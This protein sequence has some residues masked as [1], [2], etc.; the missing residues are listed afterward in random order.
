MNYVCTF[1][2]TRTNVPRAERGKPT[3]LCIASNKEHLYFG[4]SSNCTQAR[5][6]KTLLLCVALLQTSLQVSCLSSGAPAAACSTLS[7]NPTQHGA[8]PQI[9]TV[10][11]IVDLVP[12]CDSA[13]NTYMYYPGQNYTCKFNNNNSVYF[14]TTTIIIGLFKCTGTGLHTCERNQAMHA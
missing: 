9:S 3:L 1:L 4:N 14:A 7:P 10:P 2:R 5:N 11:Y 8:Q 6:M 13:T 12:F